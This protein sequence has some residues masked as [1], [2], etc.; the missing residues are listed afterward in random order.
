MSLIIGIDLGTTNSE[1]AIINNGKVELVEENGSAMLP[2]YVGLSQNGVL[3]VGE[4]ARNQYILHPQNTIKSIKRKMGS[5]ETVSLGDKNYSPQEISAMILRE[6]KDRAERKLGKRVEKAVITVPAYF[7]DSQRQ[8]TRD[9][10]A[11]AG[12]EVVRILNEPTAAC[13]AYEN[14]QGEQTKTVMAFDLGGGTFDVSI[15][16]M[17]G[18]LVEVIGSHGDNQLGGD[19]IDEVLFNEILK[20]FY[21]KH[22]SKNGALTEVTLNRLQRAAENA[23]IQLSQS[24]SSKIIEDN[25]NDADDNTHQLQQEISRDEFEKLTESLLNRTLVSIHQAMAEARVSIED[26]DDV[27][28][29][30]GS[31]RIP[32]I[33]DL[34]ESELS[35]RPR[36]EVHPDYAVAYGAGVMAARLMGEGDQRILIDITPFTFGTS[37]LG[38][39]NGEYC[40]YYYV[41]ILHAGSPLPASRGQVFYTMH[42]GQPQIHINVFQGQERDARKNVYLGEFLVEGLDEDAEENSSILI[43][44]NLD[45]DGILTVTAIE[46]E[47]GL[48]KSVRLENTLQKVGK[49]ELVASQKKIAELFGPSEDF[50]EETHMNLDDEDSNQ[51]PEDSMLTQIKTRIDK[52]KDELDTIDREDLELHLKTISIA[53]LEDDNNTLAKATQ[54][55]DDILFYVESAT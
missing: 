2:S 45:L 22:G 50:L 28:L 40:P 47:T 6:L 37:T 48:S 15:V 32:A 4:E 51:R 49:Q 35:K 14:K 39:V 23:K 12:L 31:T 30:G 16:R 27:L 1:V 42:P 13:L 8:A 20:R 10:G 29:V 36:C 34:L 53:L 54:E 43:N 9:A 19:D 33:A 55:I 44:M 11:I 18:E 52:V 25:L 46:K 3:I 26:I 7:S 41:P 21:E 17:T 5:E 24:A 38:E